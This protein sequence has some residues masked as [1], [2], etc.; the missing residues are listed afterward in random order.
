MDFHSLKKRLL[1]AGVRE[2]GSGGIIAWLMRSFRKEDEYILE[3]CCTPFL[4]LFKDR[5]SYGSGW[6]P[7]SNELSNE[8]SCEISDPPA[9]ALVLQVC[10][11]TFIF[12]LLCVCAVAVVPVLFLR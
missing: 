8:Y 9:S 5:I 11:A 10:A 2:I 6:L 3:T 1:G 12:Y 4:L 7:T